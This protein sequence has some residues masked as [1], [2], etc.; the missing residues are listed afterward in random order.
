M[1]ESGNQVVSE[2]GQVLREDEG[3]GTLTVDLNKNGNVKKPETLSK[4]RS[5]N[6]Q[7]KKKNLE[8]EQ[9]NSPTP[10]KL[11]HRQCEKNTCASAVP[12]CFATASDRCAGSGY[13]SRWYHITSGEHYCNE[14]FDYYYRSHRGGNELFSSWKRHWSE[15]SR[16]EAS[17]KVFM[18]DKMLPFWAQCTIPTCRKFRQLTRA[19]ELTSEFL[20]NFTCNMTGLKKD[21]NACQG[22]EDTRVQPLKSPNWFEMGT[23][24]ALLIN[25][26]ATKFLVNYYPD[27]VGISPTS[28]P[29]P[30][31]LRKGGTPSTHRKFINKPISP[32]SKY[33][34]CC[35]FLQP[36]Y[37]PAEQRK[38]LCFRPD[39]ME[40]DEMNEFPEYVCDRVS[41]LGV[42]NT[43][44]ALWNLNPKKWITKESL[45]NHIICRGLVRIHL[46]EMSGRVLECL[47]KKGVVNS[48]IVNSPTGF[49]LLPKHSKSSVIVIGSGPSGLAA[50]HHLKNLGFKVTV[51]EAKGR[52]GGRI[53]DDTLLGGICVGKGAQIV[54]GVINNLITIMC[55]QAGIQ[56]RIIGEKCDLYEANGSLA[57]IEYDQRVDFHFNAMLDSIAEWRK[58]QTEDSSLY[59]KL[60]EMHNSFSEE[61]GYV[62]SEEEE[63]LLQFHISNLE[64]ACGTNLKNVSALHWDQNEQFPQLAGHH[65]LLPCGYSYLMN[66]FAEGLDIHFNCEVSNVNSSSNLVKVTTIDGR[67]FIADK[68]II[69]V[70]LAILQKNK[71]TFTPSLPPSKISAM[72]KLGAG[73]IEKIGLQF[74]TCFWEEKLKGSDF[75][76]HVPSVPEEKGLFS[77]FYDLTP[78]KPIKK[79]SKTYILMS[80]ISGE[81]VKLMTHK[82]DEEIVEMCLQVLRKMF[83]NKNVPRPLNWFVTRW[84]ED[85]HIGMSYS[86]IKVEGK[87]EDYDTMAEQIGDKIYFAGEATNRQFPQTVSGALISGVREA[88]KIINDTLTRRN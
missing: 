17:I 6:R 70:P 46:L 85:P 32:T 24:T 56:M 22:P 5:S 11:H 8:I 42:R 48:G 29:I 53:W 87:G 61:T 86:Y 14:C 23:V 67:P 49:T 84:K 39:V 45:A 57:S 43:I 27:G 74:S 7:I 25:S 37:Q 21:F 30:D 19:S 80:Y 73:I 44:I 20:A 9:E 12:I 75:F 36:F 13:T 64:Y 55:E 28:I 4:T 72:N 81:E 16:L 18:V 62:F 71:I 68:V 3:I 76:G 33:T 54:T 50:A 1:S 31:D 15:N 66:L 78:A 34:G 2:P 60:M 69:T 40:T 52:I 65:T 63:R 35:E 58:G 41:Y 26:P 10:A 79:N 38:A 59:D 88:E 77:I 83:Y 82:R 51:L 47:M